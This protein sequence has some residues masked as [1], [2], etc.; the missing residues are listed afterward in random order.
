[1]LANSMGSIGY[2]IDIYLLD[3]KEKI[4]RLHVPEILE[5]NN[6]PEAL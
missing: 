4:Q 6:L 2:K 1:M 5:I 3:S